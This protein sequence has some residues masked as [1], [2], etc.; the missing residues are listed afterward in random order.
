MSEGTPRILITGASGFIA[1]WIAHGALKLGYKVR[2]TVRDLSNEAKIGH[3][4]KNLCPG[5]KHEIELVEADLLNAADWV[6]AVAD[7]DYI[8][9]TASP[10]PLDEPINADEVMKPAVDG[11]LNVL[12]AVSSMEQLPKRVIFTSCY[13]AVGLGVDPKNKVFT[14]DDWTVTDSTTYPVTAI[15]RSKVLA[16]RAAW[17]FVDSLSADR[18]FD[19]TV[20]NPSMPLG[21]MLS[22]SSCASTDILRKIVLGELQGVPDINSGVISV[23]EVARAHLKALTEPKVIGKRVLLNQRTLS[24]RDLADIVKNVFEPQGYYPTAMGVSSWLIRTFAAVGDRSAVTVVNY[25]GL[26]VVVDCVNARELLGME[27]KPDPSIVV[28]MVNAAIHAGLIVDKSP[29]Q[30]ITNSYVLPELDVTDIPTANEC[31]GKNDV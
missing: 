26:N 5:S 11:T 30:Q 15:H 24:I 31:V 22:R 20:L 13:Y 21:P 23:L 12:R 25:L 27:L 18:K 14:D 4:N 1:S 17:S 16:E 2:G 19:L 8:I 9:H 29:G 7:C 10:F 3:L 6:V 28:Q